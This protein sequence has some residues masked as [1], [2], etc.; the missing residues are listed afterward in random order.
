MFEVAYSNQ[1][2]SFFKKCDKTLAKRLLD[3]IEQLRITPILRETIIVEGYREKL[4][5]VRVGDY[6]ILYEVDFKGNKLGIVKIDKRGRV[7]G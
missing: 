2:N 1:A 6:R 7:Y 3:K 4:Y 5:R